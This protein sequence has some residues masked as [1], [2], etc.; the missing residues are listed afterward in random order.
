MN[1]QGQILSPGD[2]LARV[3]AT[4]LGAGYSP[5]APGTVGTLVTVP[6]AYGL[7][8]LGGAVLWP[9]TL[10]VIVVAVWAASRAERVLG[11]HDSSRIVV[12]EAAGY[13]VA[14]SIAPG[15]VPHLFFAFVLFR[16]F[17]ILKPPPIGAIDRHVKGGL[18]VVMD[19]VLAGVYAAAV[20]FLLD[21]FG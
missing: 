17:D 18:G 3:I 1:V 7:G 14:V 9:A 19:D 12:D 21:R 13:L 4:M 11:E 5:V 8:R 10:A 6:L 2:R 15:S 20:L 16:V